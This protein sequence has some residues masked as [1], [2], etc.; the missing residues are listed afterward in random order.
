MIVRSTV[1]R[2]VRKLYSMKIRDSS[3]RCQVPPPISRIRLL[4]SF[5]F[6]KIDQ[7][8][9]SRQLI[10]IFLFDAQMLETQTVHNP[11]D[12]FSPKYEEEFTRVC[13]RHPLKIRHSGRRRFV[14]SSSTLYS[15]P[16]PLLISFEYKRHSGIVM[17]PQIIY[18]VY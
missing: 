15:I 17:L 14:Q 5:C 11:S 3:L 4:L 2:T 10:F 6:N 8:H 12:R 9:T 7:T 18:Q 1:G 13:R 16:F